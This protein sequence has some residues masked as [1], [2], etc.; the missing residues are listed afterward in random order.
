[1]PVIYVDANPNTICIVPERRNHI[2]EDLP[3][4]LHSNNS[5]EYMA[6]V[7]ALQ[8]ARGMR[9]KPIPCTEIISDSLL[10]VN[11]LNGKFQIKDKRLARL[12]KLCDSLNP[13]TIKY[14]WKPREENE[15]GKILG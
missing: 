4:G 8:F 13:G 3:T 6:V 5:A 1:M 15:A 11:Q 10:I 9:G 12:K 14:T 7:I 2:K